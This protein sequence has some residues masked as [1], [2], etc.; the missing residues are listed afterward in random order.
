MIT[1]N[2]QDEHVVEKMKATVFI[3]VETSLIDA[4]I[5]RPGHQYI[6]ADQSLS[7]T[8]LLTAAWGSMYDLY[9]KKEKGVRSISNHHFPKDFKADPLNDENVLAELWDVLDKAQVAVAH[10]AT[11]DKGWITSRFLQLGWPLPSKTSWVCTLRGLGRYNFTSKKLNELSQ[12]LVGTKKIPTTFDLW[13]RCSS[14]EVS[15]FKEM[16]RYNEGDIFDTLFKVYMTTCPY[17]PDYCVDMADYECEVPQCKVTGELLE[18]LEEL[19][20]DRRNGCEYATYI[21]PLGIRYKDR[22]NT[23][24]NKAGKGYVVHYV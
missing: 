11:F 24:S 20:V 15:A 6:P 5:F 23:N 9:T 17:Y 8:R 18:E 16:L 7:T 10:N 19:H 2:L 1:L 22:Y 21:S 14:G 13:N 3:D 12:L 4:R